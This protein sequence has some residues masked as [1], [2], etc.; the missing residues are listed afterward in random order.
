MLSSPFAIIDFIAQSELPDG[1]IS[2]LYVAGG[3]IERAAKGWTLHFADEDA[4][5]G[6]ERDEGCLTLGCNRRSK[7]GFALTVA[8]VARSLRLLE[9]LSAD[10]EVQLVWTASDIIIDGSAAGALLQRWAEIAEPPTLWIIA[11]DLDQRDET[12]FGHQTR[13]LM[14]FVDHELRVK[15]FD[16]GQSRSAAQTIS[17]IAR[18]ALM[19]G[20]IV[21]GMRFRGLD[22][23]PLRL[24]WSQFTS[25]STNMVTISL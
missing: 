17:R 11:L 24:D 20:P 22:D 12:G 6:I 18:H 5:I 23:L 2:G 14:P 7:T 19:Y 16:Q 9:A 8:D 25:T 15:F 21:P 10:A 1:K 13:G 4:A 3:Q